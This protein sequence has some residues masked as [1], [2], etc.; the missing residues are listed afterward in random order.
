V[1]VQSSNH[2]ADVLDAC[3]LLE[4]LTL[5]HFDVPLPP[6]DG[7]EQLRSLALLPTNSPGDPRTR[8]PDVRSLP[9]LELLVVSRPDADELERIA[10]LGLR[11]LVVMYNPEYTL[12]YD[13][14][15]IVAALARLDTLEHLGLLWDRRH[16]ADIAPLSKLT[17][18]RS[19]EISGALHGDLHA[20]ATL[21]RLCFS[22]WG[23]DARIHGA[24]PMV[25]TGGNPVYALQCELERV[26]TLGLSARQNNVEWLSRSPDRFVGVETLI[27]EHVELQHA[28]A[29]WLRELPRLRTVI[30][31]QLSIGQQRA[32]AEALPHLQILGADAARL[33]QDWPAPTSFELL[34][35]SNWPNC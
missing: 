6:I 28:W 12:H 21:E 10:A 7:L 22:R 24:I 27:L 1:R 15:D 26:Q 18:L 20:P 25:H 3:P 2:V 31:P 16:R 17:R 9:R 35:P 4:H 19:L 23:G 13:A 32:T 33:R 11:S 8:L 29:A 30:W 5:H 34:A 14:D